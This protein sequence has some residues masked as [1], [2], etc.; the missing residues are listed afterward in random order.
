MAEQK[1]T[2]SLQFEP[3]LAG[4]DDPF[5]GVEW[6]Q[7]NVE[8]TNPDGE[9]I[10]HREGVTIPVDWSEMSA[11]VV[12]NQYFKG[13]HND[14]E[15]ENSVKDM[16]ERVVST[17]TKWGVSNSYFTRA[18][19][20]T[21]SRELTWILLHQHAS[22][23]SPV[24]YNVGVEENPQCSACFIQSVD[25]DMGSIM[26]LQRSESMLFKFGSGTGTNLSTL[27]S[28]REYVSGGGL[29]SGPVSFMRGYD[30]W[31]GTIKSGGK[32]RRAA[33]MQILDVDHPDIDIFINCKAEAEKMAHA[34][35]D[36]GYSGEFNVPGNAYDQVPYQNANT[37]VRVTDKFMRSVE[38]E[39]IWLT[40]FR[41]KN[42]RGDPPS[43]NAHEL[44]MKIVEATWI[45][46]D[47]GLQFDTI[48]NKW[49]TCPDA[50]RINASNP[51]V[52][53]MFLDDSA[54]N[55]A[56]INLLKF[57]RDGKFDVHKFKHAV[58]IIITAQEIII[59]S[60]S[61]PTKLIEK[62]SKRFRPLGLGYTNLGAFLMSCGL[63]YDSDRARVYAGSITSLMT[64][65]AYCQSARLAAIK[66]PCSGYE[67]DNTLRVVKR[68]QREMTRIA[69]KGCEFS[70]PTVK[71]AIEYWNEA[72]DLGQKHG[73]RN[74]Q[75]SLLAPTGT[76]SFM[77]DCD[78]TGIEPDI[79]LVKNK[80]LVG[81]GIQKLVNHSVRRAMG[82][83]GYTSDEADKAEAYILEHGYIE[84]CHLI[85]ESDIEVFDC[86]LAAKENGRYISHTGHIKMMA[87]VQP[88]LSGAISKTVNLPGD[89]TVQDISDA[90]L[91]AWKLGL[92][93]VA[94]Y[95]D[96]SKKTQPM[97]VGSSKSD[98]LLYP[99]RR[100]PND[101][102]ANRHRFTIGGHKGYIIVSEFEDG[103][104]G[105]IFVVMNKQGSTIN[106]LMD[107][108]A[109]LT[110]IALQYGVPLD[111]LVTKFSH[112]RFEPAGYTRSELG[113]ASSLPDYIFRWL[114]NKYLE[115]HK[116]TEVTDLVGKSIN[117]PITQ[118]THT[119][120]PPPSSDAPPCHFCGSIMVRQGKCYGCSV[121]GATS[122]CS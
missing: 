91:Q 2:K 122:G 33:K 80:K 115:D 12:A 69:E 89:A 46:G 45:C 40:K 112:V 119:P 85:Q 15:A 108:I 75:L 73:F 83:L 14:P 101:C 64:A 82:L 4:N 111:E 17:I 24:W 19:G 7:R 23:N 48:I 34:L 13:G 63:P 92:K 59:D 104:P 32:T 31:A 53:F 116:V 65:E 54:C 52:E 47:P 39:G 26:D 70:H 18:H 96:G 66:R 84:D 25:D 58:D 57:W 72:A 118:T 71:A 22:F 5:E 37:S 114:G 97:N 35:I 110:S 61:Y 36:A 68:H 41:T 113:F 77:M 102:P 28:S 21:F 6:D 16:I 86:A 100:L 93:A 9:V 43:F 49:H 30:A 79:A 90:Y 67:H 50:G 27:R 87:A 44:F 109:T 98:E 3:L 81:G 51:C 107:T 29:A 60:A 10:F 94:V 62:N 95:R 121:C 105:E 103:T 99:R 117:V 38:A 120:S 78:T 55:L 106:G 42:G 56:S 20:K 74:T 88:F 76:I 11:K 1:K 8:I